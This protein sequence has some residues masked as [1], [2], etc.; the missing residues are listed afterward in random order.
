MEKC[1]ICLCSNP[2]TITAAF[3]R[4]MQNPESVEYKFLAK[5]RQ[6]FPSLRIVKKSHASPRQYTNKSGE[7]FVC[8][9]FK[10]LTYKHMESFIASLPKSEEYIKA[11]HF[12]KDACGR[13][14][15]NA[16]AVVRRWFAE[17]F[18]QYRKNPLFYLHN[19]PDIV[20]VT[21]YL[22]DAAEKKAS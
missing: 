19:D 14:Q 13:L 5:V 11:Y 2:I 21:K 8:N 9:P 7:T 16:Y 1:K 18:P 20:E 22:P 4:A 15:I 3:E 12:L 10:N 6:D 17:Q